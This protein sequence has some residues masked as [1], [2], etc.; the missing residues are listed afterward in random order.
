MSEET[1]SLEILMRS[2][3]EGNVGPVEAFLRAFLDG[4]LYVPEREQA[5]KLSDSPRYPDPF[6]NILGIQDK[7]RV[8][9][10]VFTRPQLILDWC[11]N[12]LRYRTLRS[13]ELLKILPE[14]W[15]LCI[16]PA[17]EFEKELSPWEI[18][19]LRSGERGI[20]AIAEEIVQQQ[21]IE[22]LEIQPVR[23][24]E[25]PAV[26]SETRTFAAKEPA[27]LRM[28]LVR[29]IGKDVDEQKLQKLFLGVEL[30]PC[31]QD[32]ATSIQAEIQALVDRCQVGSDHIAVNASGSGTADLTFGFFANSSPYYIA[33]GNAAQSMW[34]R[35]RARIGL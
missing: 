4:T 6:L 31:P 29:H 15:W 16:N 2:A 14:E 9:V 20:P 23:E 12:E 21:T 10:P 30:A 27:I 22:P 32:R 26:V 13:I 24:S 19:Q 11:G 25:F 7:E 33:P 28:F 35:L 18:E 5:Q 34:Q 17:A 8:V 1:S 3:L